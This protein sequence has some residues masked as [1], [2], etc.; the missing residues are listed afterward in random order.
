MEGFEHVVV[1][2]KM[3]AQ[4]QLLLLWR[5]EDARAA[6]IHLVNMSLTLPFTSLPP[7]ASN[8]RAIPS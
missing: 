2:V 4:T 3:L 8:A 6:Q 7:T 5:L 1:C